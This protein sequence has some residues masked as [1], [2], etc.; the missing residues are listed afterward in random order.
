MKQQ[1]TLINDAIKRNAI[2]H[3]QSLPIDARSPMVIEAREETRTEKQNRLMW[4]LLK[5]LSEQ[6]PWYGEKL[7][8]EEWK[9]VITVLV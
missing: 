5:D 3:I 7:T 2:A 8:R 4:P 9:D 1:Y 6:V